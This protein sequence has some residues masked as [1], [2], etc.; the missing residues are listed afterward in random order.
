MVNPETL[1]RQI[2]GIDALLA[3]DGIIPSISLYRSKMRQLVLS[4]DRVLRLGLSQGV[5]IK[6]FCSLLCRLIDNR[7]RTLLIRNRQI[8]DGETLE[9]ELYGPM[10]DVSPLSERLRQLLDAQDEQIRTLSKIVVAY[11]P[12]LEPQNAEALQLAISCGEDALNTEPPLLDV[13]PAPAQAQA[14]HSVSPVIAAWLSL[15]VP[16]IGVLLLWF[17]LKAH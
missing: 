15:G 12:M 8:Q 11:L 10:L 7:I 9:A 6:Q 5:H 16:L 3:M 1:L 14:P 13:E 17:Y 2:I 4:L